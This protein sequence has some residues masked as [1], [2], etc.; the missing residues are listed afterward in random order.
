MSTLAT[1]K[2]QNTSESL[3]KS[4]ERFIP[5]DANVS[6]D[7]ITNSDISHAEFRAYCAILGYG[8]KYGH[9]SVSNETFLKDNPVFSERQFQRHCE[10]LQ[11]KGFIYRFQHPLHRRGSMRYIIPKCY[12]QPFTKYII[13]KHKR[14]GWAAEVEVF[15]EGGDYESLRKSYQLRIS[16]SFIKSKSSPKYKIA[17]SSTRRLTSAPSDTALN[18]RSIN[19][20]NIIKEEENSERGESPPLF[21]DFG[22][23][24]I[25]QDLVKKELSTQQLDWKKGWHL[26]QRC[27]KEF[28]AYDNPIAGLVAALKGGYAD[29]KIHKV[30]EKLCKEKAAIDEREKKAERTKMGHRIAQAIQRDLKHRQVD[31]K[32]YDVYV[33]D[34]HATIKPHDTYGS[35]YF[36]YGQPQTVDRLI[37]FAQKN[38]INIDLTKEKKDE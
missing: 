1:K 38:D 2:T 21:K 30:E 36:D 32:Q 28:D 12:W 23:E 3:E 4:H 15:F 25:S 35:Y 37:Q 13:K 24:K 34:R 14:A 6:Y 7:D 19:N 10:A 11:E 18:V 29:E 16:G 33:D 5:H 8:K 22:K 26:Y 31:E 17:H 20:I 9:L 27:K